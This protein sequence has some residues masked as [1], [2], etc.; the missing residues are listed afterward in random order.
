MVNKYQIKPPPKRSGIIIFND[1]FVLR[2][3]TK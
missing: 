2:F 1:F 3:K